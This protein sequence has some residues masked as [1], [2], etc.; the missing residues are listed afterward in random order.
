[1]AGRLPASS[2]QPYSGLDWW[3][4]SPIAHEVCAVPSF[5]VTTSDGFPS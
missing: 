4:G 3:D 2:L 1:V 5:I